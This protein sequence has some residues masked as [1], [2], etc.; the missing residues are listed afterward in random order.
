L[1]E[2]SLHEIVRHAPA[3]VAPL[4]YGLH[5]THARLR[6]TL[7]QIEQD[8]AEV[9]TIFEHMADSVLVLDRH[10]RVV[11]SN[12]AAARMLRAASPLGRTLADVSRDADLVELA[13]TGSD[14]LPAAQ[15]IELT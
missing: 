14:E 8:R 4:L 2:Q 11:L 15:V 9:A 7:R 13:R 5:V 6:R 12:P 1:G 10:E 3:E